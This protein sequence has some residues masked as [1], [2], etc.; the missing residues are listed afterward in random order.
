MVE[1]DS[2]WR[3]AKKVLGDW[4]RG[5]DIIRLNPELQKNPGKLK[6]GQVLKVP[7]KAP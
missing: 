5:E 1:G 3:I 6:L 4:H 2:V 7:A